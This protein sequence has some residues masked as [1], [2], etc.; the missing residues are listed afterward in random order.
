VVVFKLAG[1][2]FYL[3]VFFPCDLLRARIDTAM[4]T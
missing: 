2:S 4:A 1:A 3:V